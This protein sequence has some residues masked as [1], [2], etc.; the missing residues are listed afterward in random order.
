M[1]HPGGIPPAPAG[2]GIAEV[3]GRLNEIL[4]GGEESAIKAAEL[5]LAAG[6]HS[7]CS[8]IHIEPMEDRLRIRFR[9]LGNLHTAGWVPREAGERLVA[10]LKVLARVPTYQK[11]VPQDGRLRLRHE[12]RDIDLRLSLLPALHGEK[13]VVRFPGSA[14]RLPG[15]GDLG[16]PEPL[17]SALEAALSRPQGAL[18]LTGPAGSGKTTTLYAALRH[19]QRQRADGCHILTLED[20]VERDLEGITQSQVNPAAGI[21]FASGL[22]AA[23]RQDPDV[24]MIGEIRDRETAEIAVQA[25]LTG[26]LILSTLHSGT[27]AGVF[28]RLVNLEIE[29]YLIASSVTA[30]LA[31]R[32]V[33]TICPGCA[34]TA[35]A[36]ERLLARLPGGDKFRDA[37]F[38]RGRGC[39]ACGECG[40]AGRTGVFELLAVDDDLR[41]L[42]LAR[43][44]GRRLLDAAL[45]RGYRTLLD[46]ALEKARA[47]LTTLEEALRLA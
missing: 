30:V 10:R 2:A 40:Y 37:G 13:A 23:L 15:V 20:P 42:I 27:A 44:G 17:R 9:V 24:I 1:N 29:P 39:P 28:S 35:P 16:L 47:G 5:L 31:Q 43:A 22:R 14:R 36:P 38:R 46:D 25:G 34:E 21:T 45:R 6:A 4:R 32:L 12:G 3:H 11:R 8:D 41:E 7:Q 33:R 18:L 19:I 26:H